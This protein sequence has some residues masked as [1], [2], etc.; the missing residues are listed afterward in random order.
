M[1]SWQCIHTAYV[2]SHTHQ[3]KT[4]GVCERTLAVEKREW[5]NVR[6]GNRLIVDGEEGTG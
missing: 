4:I 5:I 3:L 6:G 1:R 2:F